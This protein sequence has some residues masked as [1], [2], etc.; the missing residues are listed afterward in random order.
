MRILLVGNDDPELEV[1]AERLAAAGFEVARAYSSAGALAQL[2]EEWRPV[3]I[4]DEQTPDMHGIVFIEALR[5]R[6]FDDM[7]VIMLTASA[8]FDQERGYIAGVDD[9]LARSAPDIE[10]FARVRAAFNTLA[11]RRSLTAAESE[12]EESARVDPQSGAC[13]PRE[14]TRRL[15][16]E[17]RR[18][19]RYGRQIS[20]VVI[21]VSGEC[22]ACPAPE[23]LRDLVRTIEVNARANVDWVGRMENA[24][25]AFVL[26][27]PEAAIVD[28]PAIMERVLNALRGVATSSG[29]RLAFE[30]GLAALDRTTAEG[31]QIDAGE[32]LEAAERCL[33]CPGHVGDEQLLAVQRSVGSHVAIACRHGYVVDSQCSM[34]GAGDPDAQKQPYLPG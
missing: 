20:V 33:K 30:A 34:K 32:L 16:L 31:V 1:A 21:H 17:I 6:S 26:A 3:V 11:L 28:A 22:G 7:Y 25:A 19:Q 18:A 29:A 23:I 2:T 9:Y 24:S 12:P 14:L 4:T 15:Q 5:E 13:A 10:L 27:L 8:D